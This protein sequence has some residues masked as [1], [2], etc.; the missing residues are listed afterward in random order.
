MNESKVRVRK[1]RNSVRPSHARDLNTR[2]PFASS[3]TTRIGSAELPDVRLESLAV[4]DDDL[5]EPDAPEEPDDEP[6][7]PVA[8]AAIVEAADGVVE[9]VD[10]GIDVLF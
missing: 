2:L 8:A 9:I 1:V 3:T 10:G 5:A 4:L 7:E 6:C